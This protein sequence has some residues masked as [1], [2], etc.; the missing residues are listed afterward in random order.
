MYRVFVAISGE[1]L[2]CPVE[3]RHEWDAMGLVTSMQNRGF[4]AWLESTRLERVVDA[5]LIRLALRVMRRKRLIPRLLR[6]RAENF[7]Y[8]YA[9]KGMI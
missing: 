9:M 6:S 7:E 4:D 2:A 8:S 3:F 5:V 1:A